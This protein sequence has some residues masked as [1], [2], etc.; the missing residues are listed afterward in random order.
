MTRRSK[1]VTPNFNG[2]FVSRR[3]R[4][5]DSRL[6]T[7]SITGRMP[8]PITETLEGYESGDSYK[9]T[10]ALPIAFGSSTHNKVNFITNSMGLLSTNLASLVWLV[11]HSQRHRKD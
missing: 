1:R 7:R 11:T 6:P 4:H 3:I 8:R 9:A 10:E 2:V 5:R